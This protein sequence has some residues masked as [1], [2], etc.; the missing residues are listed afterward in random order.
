MKDCTL[1]QNLAENPTPVQ[2]LVSKYPDYLQYTD[3]CRLVS[4]GVTTPRL[5]IIQPW[6]WHFSWPIYIQKDLVL[7]KNTKVKLTINNLELARLV[8]EWLVLEYIVF[9]DI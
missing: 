1:L 9:F 7:D 2:T 8:L 3:A 5:Y 6:V 4:G